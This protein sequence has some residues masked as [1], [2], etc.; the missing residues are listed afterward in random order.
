MRKH[1]ARE[2][3]G[4]DHAGSPLQMRA[5]SR[6]ECAD[7]GA[8]RS[9]SLGR[10]FVGGTQAGA[11]SRRDTILVRPMLP[12][13]A[14]VAMTSLIVGAP[15][16][17]FSCGSHTGATVSLADYAGKSVMLWFYPRASTGG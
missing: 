10:R 11:E 7:C 5:Q 8:C 2:G 14:S 16:P 6:G 4:H 17:T 1:H 13:L 9:G 12:V 3:K 15:A